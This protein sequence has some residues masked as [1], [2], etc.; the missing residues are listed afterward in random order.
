LNTTKSGGR[1]YLFGA[2]S[3][4]ARQEWMKR[5]AQSFSP[6]DAISLINDFT[7]GG[8]VFLQ[9]GAAAVSCCCSMNIHYQLFPNIEM[10]LFTGNSCQIQ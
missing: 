10:N 7:K 5:V 2:E 6:S 9:D 4:E 8:Y 3:E 1:I